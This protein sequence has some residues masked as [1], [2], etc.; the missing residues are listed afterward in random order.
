MN[1]RNILILRRRFRSLRTKFF[2]VWAQQFCFSRTHFVSVVGRQK[3][4]S[5]F[6]P[7]SVE[8]GYAI[9]EIQMCFQ[10]YLWQFNILGAITE[11]PHSMIQ[12][13]AFSSPV[14]STVL[15]NNRS[16]LNKISGRWQVRLSR[17]QWTYNQEN[18][19][20]TLLCRQHQ[21]QMSSL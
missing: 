19:L 2:S 6:V 5:P 20:H 7:Q 17:G 14:S 12:N 3:Q 13:A 11:M 15:L 1:E 18:R 16:R 10:D 21:S 4:C 9:A 8:T